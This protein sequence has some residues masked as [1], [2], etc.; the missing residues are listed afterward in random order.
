MAASNN[1]GNMNSVKSKRRHKRKSL[2]SN[3]KGY[4]KKKC[5]GRGAQLDENTYNYY[6]RIMETLRDV[7]DNLQE[8]G[9]VSMLARV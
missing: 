6:V 2:L 4:A 1:W 8:K 5:Y 9:I 3:A 7:E